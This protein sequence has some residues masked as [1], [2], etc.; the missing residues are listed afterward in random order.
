MRIATRGGRTLVV[1]SIP[2]VEAANHTLELLESDYS[3]ES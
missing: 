3:W 2:I 1:M